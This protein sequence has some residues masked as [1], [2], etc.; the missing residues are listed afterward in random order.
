[1]RTLALALL[2]LV[3]A[4]CGKLNEITDPGGG[5]LPVDPTATFSRVQAE[6]FTPSCAALGCHDVIGRQQGLILVA[7]QAHAQIVG[8]PSQQMPSLRRVEPGNFADS[9]LYRK[10]TGTGITGDRMPPGAPQLSAAHLALVR[11]WIR[12]GAPND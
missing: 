11:D 9:Y 10:V 6:I 5:G 8:V 4:S 7:S 1:M 3:T 2:A 12:R